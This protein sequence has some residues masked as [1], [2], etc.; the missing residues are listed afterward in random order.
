VKI[1][2]EK[3]KTQEK[4]KKAAAKEAK[5]LLS[6]SLPYLALCVLV[7]IFVAIVQYYLVVI[8]PANYRNSTFVNVTMTSY[9]ELVLSRIESISES[10]KTIVNDPRLK[11]E[12]DSNDR[13]M[14]AFTARI[15]RL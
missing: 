15:D 14:F 10:A 9:M 1:N 13:N 8:A 2:K 6:Y 7:I 5:T 3:L 12:I 4:Q 11:H